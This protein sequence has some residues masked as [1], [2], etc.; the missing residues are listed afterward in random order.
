MDHIICITNKK[1]NQAYNSDVYMFFDVLEGREW[2]GIY[3]SCAETRADLDD[4]MGYL[5]SE[6]NYIFVIDISA[7]AN[8]LRTAVSHYFKQAASECKGLEEVTLK[9]QTKFKLRFEPKDIY[10]F[11]YLIKELKHVQA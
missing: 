2:D 10:E 5:E 6:D 1:R 9:G 8:K 7:G 11:M 4:F 3:E